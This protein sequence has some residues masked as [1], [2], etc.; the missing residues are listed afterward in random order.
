MNK[1]LLTER[2]LRDVFEIT[3]Y[4]TV[5][6][7][8]N[9]F[10]YGHRPR[11]FQGFLAR[12]S[13]SSLQFALLCAALPSQL[14]GK[15]FMTNP[16]KHGKTIDV[17]FQKEHPWVSD[18]DPYADRIM[19]AELQPERYKGFLTSDFS[20]RDEFSNVVR[21]NQ[22]R[23]QLKMDYKHSVKSLETMAKKM[24]KLEKDATKSERKPT[25]ACQLLPS[26][27]NA[28]TRHTTANT[29]RPIAATIPALKRLKFSIEI[30][31]LT[32]WKSL[33][34][35]ESG[36]YRTANDE[37]GRTAKTFNY[38]KPQFANKPVIK[39]TFYRRQNIFYPARTRTNFC[40]QV[41]VE[42]E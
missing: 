8:D 34:D 22:Y 3:S 23:E 31:V 5:G 24:K 38:A 15:Q 28:I 12:S 11:K 16:G 21:T 14:T 36:G 4:I 29:E 7:E 10:E 25:R 40:N 1:N 35:Q 26:V 37:I 19:Y 6:T 2:A 33:R 13:S 17:Y 39:D 42:E 30:K 20:K 9:P 32:L 18:G 41:L 27:P